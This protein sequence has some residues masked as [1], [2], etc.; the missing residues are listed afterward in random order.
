MTMRR[1]ACLMCLMRECARA[2]VRMQLVCAYTSLC[3][4]LS[5]LP[6]PTYATHL[7]RGANAT[8]ASVTSY[9]TGIEDCFCM[10]ELVRSLS[11]RA[12]QKGVCVRGRAGGAPRLRGC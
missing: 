9:L 11:V 8:N 2:R 3:A 6:T 4:P 10:P 1:H 7:C 5:T 12:V